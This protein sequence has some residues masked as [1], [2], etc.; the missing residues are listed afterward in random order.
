[1]NQGKP[2][3][4]FWSSYTLS[5]HEAMSALTLM[6]EV[7][8]EYGRRCVTNGLNL[9]LNFGEKPRCQRNESIL[10]AL[11]ATTKTNRC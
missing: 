11:V 9:K 8:R 5:L 2:F 4:I 3:V 1:M 7:L 6:Y 10:T